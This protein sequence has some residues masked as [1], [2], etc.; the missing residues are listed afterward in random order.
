M[1]QHAVSP[2]RR[3]GQVQGSVFLAGLQQRAVDVDHVIRIP[4]K[5]RHG[6][7]GISEFFLQGLTPQELVVQLSRRAPA[8][9][10]GVRYARADG[11][12][13]LPVIWSGG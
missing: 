4:A 1:A 2:G 9:L 11:G 13:T 10:D 6:A 12:S 5:G 8:H 3:R 7:L